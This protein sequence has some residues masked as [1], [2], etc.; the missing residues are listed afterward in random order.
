L[1]R[2]KR[3]KSVASNS[4]V[5]QNIEHGNYLLLKIYGK[6]IRGLIDTG[7]GTTL[8]R[9][10]IARKMNLSIRPVQKGQLSCL[11]A[12]EGSK[13]IVDGVADVTFNISG[14]SIDHTVYVVENIA[15]SLILGSDFLS[16]NQ[17]II[18]YSSKIVSMCSDLVRAPLV[19][20][21]DGQHVAKLAKSLC[22]P[23]GCEK[24]VNIKCAP[25]FSN[26]DVLVEAISCSQFT[27]FAIARSICR[28][29]KQSHTVARI[30]NCLPHTLVLP[31]ETKVATVQN[32]NVNTSCEPFKMPSPQ[33]K[34]D[35]LQSE[36]KLTPQ[37]LNQFAS[38]YGFKINPD[39]TESQRFELLNLLHRYRTCFARNLKEIRRFKN[40][41]L[42]LTLKDKRPSFRRQYKLS[43]EDALE[44]HRQ[45][46]E[47]SEC[48]I[49]EPSQNS[50]YQ[51]A[52]FT[53]RKANGQ[54]R[55][56]L[57]L[58]PINDKLEPFLLQLPDMHQLLNA[59]ASQKGRYHTTLDLASGFHQVQLKEGVSR[60]VTSFCDP[61]TGL[62]YRYTCAPF[63]LSTSP[64][65]MITVLMG[66]MSPSLVK[67]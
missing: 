50:M 27:Q 12:A 14:L 35:L 55:A 25:R 56:V 64:A 2:G 1:F 49:I 33:T 45:I 8:I 4:V 9:S 6:L 13:L 5:S 54:K 15:E 20:N 43:Q 24:I 52:I 39:L 41:E 46:N 34:T 51:S 28:T 32:I 23:P 66:I 48:G 21:G 63:G 53:V 58:R 3:G 29:D 42:E 60:D 36:N 38:E 40:Y 22:I 31:K 30:L 10:N 67:I 19:R 61:V 26:S 47:M 65:A 57:D 16:D 11:Y 62:R 18:D 7:S 44:C 59:L 37:E 17:V